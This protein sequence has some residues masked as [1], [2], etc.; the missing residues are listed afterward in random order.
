MFNW[1]FGKAS[2][3]IEPGLWALQMPAPQFLSPQALCFVAAEI[4]FNPA[5]DFQGKALPSVHY[6]MGWNEW[7]WACGSPVAEAASTR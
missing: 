2:P 1:L 3:E 4:Q 5:G 7:P 6:R